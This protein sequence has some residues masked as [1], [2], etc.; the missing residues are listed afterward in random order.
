MSVVTNIVLKTS[1]GDKHRI[2]KL[3]ALFQSGQKF[4]SCDG[5]S[6]PRGWYAGNKML[7]CEIFPGAFNQLNLTDLLNAIQKVD[8]DDPLS[9]Q[10][11]VQEQEEDRLREV[12]LRF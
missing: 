3:N 2:E 7:E 5:E 12:E 9:V 11:F 8:W 10:L 1:A 4:V 6:L